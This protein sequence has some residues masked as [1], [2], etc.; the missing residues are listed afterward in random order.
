[1]NKDTRVESEHYAFSHAMNL[2]QSTILSYFRECSVA[3]EA[4]QVSCMVGCNSLWYKKSQGPGISP[5]Y[6]EC[7][8]RLLLLEYRRKLEPK[9]TPKCLIPRLLV[10][11]TRQLEILVTTLSIENICKEHTL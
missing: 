9:E 1:M 3:N 8:S 5:G 10:V 4:L 2:K 7:G 6:Y 11:S